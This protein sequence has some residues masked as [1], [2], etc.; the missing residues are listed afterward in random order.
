MVAKSMKNI[1]N[2]VDLQS[3]DK[4]MNSLKNGTIPLINPTMRHFCDRQTS[5][6]YLRKLRL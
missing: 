1:E 5:G 2:W 6:I 3:S 4:L